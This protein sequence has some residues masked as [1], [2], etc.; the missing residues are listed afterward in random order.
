MSS[1]DQVG[2][3]RGVRQH[4]LGEIVSATTPLNHSRK[5]S[6]TEHLVS[7]NMSLTPS[8]PANTYTKS[9]MREDSCQ[10]ITMLHLDPVNVKPVNFGWTCDTKTLLMSLYQQLEYLPLSLLSAANSLMFKGCSL[11]RA[12]HQFLRGIDPN[13]SPNT[14][15]S[16]IFGPS[17]TFLTFSTPGPAFAI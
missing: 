13:P 3:S 6:S 8:S 4:L 2:L 1:A 15:E 16:R 11:S 7:R 12:R 14:S 10:S 5:S 17:T 9:K